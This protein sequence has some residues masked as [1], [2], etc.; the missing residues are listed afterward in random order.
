MQPTKRNAGLSI[1]VL[2]RA[3]I[4]KEYERFI[5]GSEKI[6]YKGLLEGQPVV[7]LVYRNIPSKLKEIVKR[8][9]QF[10]FQ[11]VD[12]LHRFSECEFIVDLIGY[13]PKSFVIVTSQGLCDLVE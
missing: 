3:T 5:G 1:T 11:E 6:V 4:A 7:F 13:D 10:F 8:N 12:I 9:S 2:D